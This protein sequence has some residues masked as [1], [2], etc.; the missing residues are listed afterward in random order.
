MVILVGGSFGA[1]AVKNIDIANFKRGSDNILGMSLGLDLVGGI[2]LF[3]QAG[4]PG[5]P[6][7]QV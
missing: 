7:S 4:D 5:F 1:L 3:D 6:L 2:H